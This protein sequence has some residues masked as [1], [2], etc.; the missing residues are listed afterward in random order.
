MKRS[1][2]GKHKG[3]EGG[4]WLGVRQRGVS[5]TKKRVVH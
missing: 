5:V 2:R 1:G 4:G 3:E